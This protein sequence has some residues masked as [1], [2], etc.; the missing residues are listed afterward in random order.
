MRSR[1][2]ILDQEGIYFLTST[3]VEWI[4]I[5]TNRKYCDIVVR[6]LQYCRTEKKLKLYA[7]VIME[8]HFHLVASSTTL[9]QTIAS[10]KKFTAK[11][12][13]IQSRINKRLW[14]LNQFSYYKKK[15][16]L[17]SN[18]QVWQE[19]F[20]PQMIINEKMLKQKIEYIHYNPVKRGLVSLPEH[21]RYSSARNYVLDDHS[22]LE[23]D[24]LPI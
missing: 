12:I 3:I 14:L 18:Y 5:F 23:M 10:L 16:K 6:S 15:Y 8:N 21:W 19:G 17:Q 24:E 13:L 1:Y 11:E 20:H 22:V 4:P 2:R 9:G 7:Y